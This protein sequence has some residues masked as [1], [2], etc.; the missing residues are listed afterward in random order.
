MIIKN[1]DIY[2]M[3]PKTISKHLR[4]GTP[5]TTQQLGSAGFSHHSLIGPAA[6]TIKGLEERNLKILNKNELNTVEKQLISPW[7][8]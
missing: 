1:E 5:S 2:R 7:L 4:V 3:F 6:E 8:N